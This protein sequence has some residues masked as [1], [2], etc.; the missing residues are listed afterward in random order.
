[1]D[2]LRLGLARKEL[3]RR[4]DGE[5]R[6]GDKERAKRGA[7]ELNDSRNGRVMRRNE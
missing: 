5:E 7:K 1:M 6:G 2:M 4:G 3:A